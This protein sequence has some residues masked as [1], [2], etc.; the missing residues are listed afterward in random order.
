VT[1][2][3][4]ACPQSSPSCGTPSRR[5]D[6]VR[7]LSVVRYL[8]DS[9]ERESQVRLKLESVNSRKWPALLRSKCKRKRDGALLA[10]AHHT[11]LYVQA[12]TWR[13]PVVPCRSP[14]C[15]HARKP[16]V[17]RGVEWVNDQFLRPVHHLCT[18]AILPAAWCGHVCEARVI[19]RVC[20]I[21]AARA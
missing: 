11:V 16:R 19:L 20:A 13:S 7:P 9:I 17:A 1:E 5:D 4:L 2:S 3:T 14:L 10:S 21:R 6:H 15:K 12:A 8:L 18:A